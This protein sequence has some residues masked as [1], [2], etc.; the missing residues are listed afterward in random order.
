MQQPSQYLSKASTAS[1][2]SLEIEI[3][4][5]TTT[6]KKSGVCEATILLNENTLPTYLIRSVTIKAKEGTFV[7]SQN[8]LIITLTRHNGR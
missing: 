1:K 3:Q 4:A 8:T 7:C 2:I 5:T 6:R